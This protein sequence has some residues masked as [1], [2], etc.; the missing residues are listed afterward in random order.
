M[1]S[2]DRSAPT[3]ANQRVQEVASILARGLLRLHTRDALA[4]SVDPH[5]TAENPPKSSQ[6]CLEVP[7]TTVL[8]GHPS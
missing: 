7:G 5:L 1:R 8:S 2:R 3:T 4:S 6:D